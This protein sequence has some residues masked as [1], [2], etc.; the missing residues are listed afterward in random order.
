[1]SPIIEE[2]ARYGVALVGSLAFYKF[3]IRPISDLL[4]LPN[5]TYDHVGDIGIKKIGQPAQQS[6]PRPH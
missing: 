1:M 3:V 2:M 4:P 6:T 5:G